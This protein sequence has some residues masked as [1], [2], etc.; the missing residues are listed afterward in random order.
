MNKRHSYQNGVP[1]F[2]DA[3]YVQSEGLYVQYNPFISTSVNNP[4]PR[5]PPQGLCDL[6]DERVPGQNMCT[7]RQ[8]TQMCRTV[9]TN[10]GP[11]CAGPGATVN[12]NNGTVDKACVV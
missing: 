10:R 6:L 11:V 7:M 8:Q 2:D 3:P 12:M 1:T 9:I 4:K 5:T